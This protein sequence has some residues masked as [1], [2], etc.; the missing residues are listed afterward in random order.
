MS[1]H[2]RLR[3]FILPLLLLALWQIAAMAYA[4]TSRMPVPGDVLTM[5][6]K[7]VS[8]G[9]LP[10]ALLQSLKRV[11]LGFACAAS[12]ALV[13]G[14][15]MAAFEPIGRNLDPIVESFRPIAPIALLPLAILWFGTGTPAAA[16]IV[17]YAAFFPM[18]VNT[19][20]GVRSIDQGVIRAARTLGVS[21]F[22]IL[23][24]VVLPGALPNLFV[25]ARLALGVAWTSIIAA[26]LAV[27]AKAGGGGSGGIGQMM[28]VFY[29]YSVDLSGI[30]VC[31]IGVGLVALIIDR[32]V[33]AL[34]F[35]MLPWKR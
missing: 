32:G 26:E 25:G 18:L 22:T 1:L 9:E 6:W 35:W 34:E 11:L 4:Q 7:L 24:T 14:T 29:A 30:I 5:G 28:F 19:I 33:R 8:S 2:L 13:V 16:F 3:P 10:L 17:G 21:R 31:M 20:H 15:A 12:L 27:G 23:R